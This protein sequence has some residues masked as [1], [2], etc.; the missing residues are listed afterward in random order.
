MPAL[1]LALALSLSMGLVPVLAGAETL[2]PEG[3]GQIALSFAPVVKAAAPAVVN[4]YATRLVE[5]R[6]NPFAGDPFFEEFFRD[7]AP[8]RQSEQNSLGSGVIVGPEG[9]VVSN[10]HV[11]EGA[12]EI[13]VVLAD[14]R[15]FAATVVLADREAD[16]AVLR[17][18]GAADLPALPLRDSDSLEVGDLV[19]AIGNPFGVG[20]TV[21]SGIVSGLAR[22]ALAVGDG[23]GYFVQTDAPINPG[24]SGGALVDTRGQLIGIN[25]AILSKGGGSNGIGF[26]IP[27]NMVAAF[28]AQAKAGAARFHRPWAGVSGQAVDSDTAQALDIG[29]P[30]GVILSA[31][32]PDSPFAKAG[33]A[34][35]DVVLSLAG[36]ETNTP[37]EMLYRLSVLGLGATAAVTYLRDGA[38]EAAEVTLAPAPDSPPREETRVADEVVLQGAVLVRI[39]P[40][41]AEEQGLPAN[42]DGVLVT[43]ATGVAEAAGLRAGDILVAVNGAQVR[44]PAEVMAVLAQGGRRWQLD[45]IRQGQPVTLRVRF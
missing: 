13:R 32:H 45:V 41:V 43:E 19:L 39:N 29:L 8:S 25:T 34:A 21:S 31:L 12:T 1:R 22:S 2:V 5:E 42:A 17:L 36:H 20:Q 15:E 3:Q 26:A 14:R 44:R 9:T 23:R 40:A 28:V 16:L 27:S 30:R 24:N 11:I 35:G 7:L 10:F 33:L 6:Q 38:E 18:E 4:I 37:Q